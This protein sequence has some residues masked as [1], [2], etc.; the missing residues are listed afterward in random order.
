MLGKRQI[1]PGR[2]QD[3][4]LTAPFQHG[5]QG[6]QAPKPCSR[7]APLQPTCAPGE[8]HVPGGQRQ[9]RAEPRHA[10]QDW[11]DGMRGEQANPVHQTAEKDQ[12]QH[13]PMRQGCA[14]VDVRECQQKGDKR[15]PRQPP[16]VAMRERGDQHES[17]QRGQA[18]RPG[19]KQSAR[20]ARATRSFGGGGSSQLRC[21]PC[22]NVRNHEP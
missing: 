6:G 5:P 14:A 1:A 18:Q 7:P 17:G 13:G 12:A 10:P 2:A 20:G 21:K 9:H 22:Y 15:D 16:Q 3:A 4:E 11:P 19:G 8:G